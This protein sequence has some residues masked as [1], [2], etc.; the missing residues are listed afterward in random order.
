M[1]TVEIYDPA[2]CCSSGV[3]GPSPDTDLA[4]FAACVETLKSV[5][6]A[7]K[8]YNLAQEPLAFAQNTIVKTVLETH[9][10]SSLP[11]IFV[12]GKANFRGVYPTQH[13]LEKLLQ[14]DLSAAPACCSEDSSC[15]SEQEDKAPMTFVKVN[16]PQ[17]S[18]AKDACCDPSTGCC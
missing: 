9:G 13:Q 8:R 3:C 16:A 2:L 17:A 11:M 15:C 7:V 5:G 18:P 1:N 6:I 14:I 10:E 4:E 12:N